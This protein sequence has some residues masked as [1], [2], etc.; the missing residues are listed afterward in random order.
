LS[1]RLEKTG[2]EVD[3]ASDGFMALEK[4]RKD[5]P[6]LVILDLML[7]EVDGYKVCRMLKFD[8][9]Y[10]NI[11]IIML[12]GRTQKEDKNKGLQMGADAYIVKPFESRYL[13]RKIEE[14]LGGR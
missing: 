3:S 5:R 10:K 11:P 9:A 14:L 8:E 1:M 13:L 7:P 6:D 12:T 4:I 2:Y